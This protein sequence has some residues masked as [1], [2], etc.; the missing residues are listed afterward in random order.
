MQFIWPL[1][2]KLALPVIVIIA[3]FKLG[4]WMAGTAAV[5]VFFGI[6]GYFGRAGVYA[7]R[8]SNAYNAGKQEE[9]L[10]LFEKAHRT[11]HM[12][13]HQA[14]SYGYLLL[15]SGRTEQ[16]EGVLTQAMQSRNKNRMERLMVET[17]YALLLWKLGR[18]SE[19]VKLLEQ[20]RRDYRHTTVYGSLGYLLLLEGDL[21]HALDVNLEA[22]QFNDSDPVILD[23]LGQTYIARGEFEKAAELYDK[24]EER[25]PVFPEAYYYHALVLLH[26]EK[27]EAARA[28]LQ[29]ALECRFT[30]LQT[31]TRE[32]VEQ[33][34]ASLPSPAEA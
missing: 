23:N 18:V 28:K 1:L 4:G 24:L 30:A 7:M 26:Q 34:L 19:A 2:Y 3:A 13:V 32:Q 5:L 6:L 8:A 11:G 27:T 22:V 16:A 25:K 20:L 14:S 33:R 17:N 15:R 12:A 21:D 29:Q 10:L 31:V 9:A